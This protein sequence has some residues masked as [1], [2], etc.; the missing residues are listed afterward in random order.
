MVKHEYTVSRSGDFRFLVDL[1]VGGAVSP[2][3]A[4]SG[5][6][7]VLVASPADGCWSLVSTEVS[8]RRPWPYQLSGQT[9]DFT[10]SLSPCSWLI[11]AIC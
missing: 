4:V 9:A 2:S 1:L 10:C 8:K 5:V 6:S 11:G 7:F 3:G